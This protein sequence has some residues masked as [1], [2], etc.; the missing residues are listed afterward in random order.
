MP[1]ISTLGFSAFG[2]RLSFYYLSECII[3]PQIRKFHQTDVLVADFLPQSQCKMYCHL[4]NPLLDGLFTISISF[5]NTFRPILHIR[6]DE[7]MQFLII[8]ACAK[9]I[10][11]AG[12][13]FLRNLL[14]SCLLH[15]RNFFKTKDHTEDKR[16]YI[17]G[18]SRHKNT[19]QPPNP[20]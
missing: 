3:S 5:K 1:Q 15:L 8:F 9:Q 16:Q 2:Q 6:I 19:C 7:N 12:E 17:C 18:R 14:Q 13:G 4:L 10:V 11:S 20:R